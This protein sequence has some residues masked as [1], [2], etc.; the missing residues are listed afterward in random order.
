M[1]TSLQTVGLSWQGM[2]VHP[3]K[4]AST[5]VGGSQSQVYNLLKAGE[6]KAVTLGG[7]TLITTAS[8]IDYL[9]KAQPWA[10]NRDRVAKP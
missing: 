6:L 5:I 10:P 9:A 3:I 8:L 7:K 4:R 2:P 1:T